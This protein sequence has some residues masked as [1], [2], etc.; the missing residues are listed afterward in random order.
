M[1]LSFSCLCTVVGGKLKL[2]DRI[3]FDRGLTQFMDGQELELT[4]EEVGRQRTGAQN[5][6]LWGP[7][8]G[9]F[10]ELGWAKQEAHDML[11]LMFIPKDVKLP[12]GS[13][14]RVPGHTSD[15]TVP[16]FNEFL[17]SC[18]QLA[19]ENGQ[20][21]DDGAEWRQRRGAA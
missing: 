11:A 5:R 18:I 13:V 3:G 9:A 1:K 17:D 15:L 2:F 14:V 21:I 6:F 19:A 4:I 8:I 12:D 16:E 20:I 10:M 7:V